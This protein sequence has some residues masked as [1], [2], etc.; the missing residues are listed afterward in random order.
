[1]K[2]RFTILRPDTGLDS[3]EYARAAEI[4]VGRAPV[5]DIVLETDRL[6]SRRHAAL[7]IH[8]PRAFI[9]DLGSKNGI[10]VNGI[11]YWGDSGHHIGGELELRSGDIL[12][13]GTTTFQIKVVDDKDETV[14]SGFY[15]EIGSGS[16]S[17]PDIPGY[18]LE[19]HIGS[20]GMGS[21]FFARDLRNG[22]EVA[23]KVALPCII[24]D[25]HIRQSFVRE[26]K[27]TRS[28]SHPNIVR[29][30][31]SG[32][33]PSGIV[34]LVLEYMNGGSLASH[35]KTR[36]NWS[37]PFKTAVPMILGLARA[38]AHVHSL[39]LVHRDIKPQNI[40]FAESGGKLVPK[41]TDL[42]LAKAPNDAFHATPGH[43]L[44]GAGTMSYMPPE[45]LTGFQR[46]GPA[47]DVFSLA[48]TFYEM[49]TGFVPYNFTLRGDNY[50]VIA[51]CDITPIAAR[52]PGVDPGLAAVFDRAFRIHPADRFRNCGELLDALRR[53]LTESA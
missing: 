25:N 30:L 50:D 53:A 3:I 48:A 1:M 26:I 6:A 13:I 28:V 24:G 2:V 21:V 38:M 19:R 47:S 11:P 10:S 31:D 18:R 34:Y 9:R 45:Q 29:F 27:V 20:G 8:P 39:G 32:V 51:T 7:R 52:L 17:F 49:L 5:S 16:V 23:I 41:I 36:P 37:I 22:A 46:A 35:L 14:D 4:T 15:S 42:G 12:A 43:A 44:M 40:L 33:A